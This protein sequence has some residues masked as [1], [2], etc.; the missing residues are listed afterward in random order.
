MTGPEGLALPAKVAAT[1]LVIGLSWLTR[2]GVHTDK[3]VIR[4]GLPVLQCSIP[5]RKVFEPWDALQNH[6]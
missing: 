6:H 4:K 5:L 1:D 3:Q 2:F